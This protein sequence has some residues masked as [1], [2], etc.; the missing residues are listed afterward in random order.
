MTEETAHTQAPH[1]EAG[2]PAPGHWSKLAAQAEVP[3]MLSFSEYGEGIGN[4]S[5]V[6]RN[7]IA[8]AGLDAAV[9]TCPGWTARDLL[10]HVGMAQRWA[11][12]VLMGGSQRPVEEALLAGLADYLDPLDWLDEGAVGVLNALVKAPAGGDY[13]F[14]LKNAPADKREAW[15]RR[16]CHEATIHGVDAMAAR[17]GAAPAAGQ[18]WFKPSLAIDGIDELLRG[19]VPRR[20]SPLRTDTAQSLAVVPTDVSAPGG[21]WTVSFGPDAASTE[22]GVSADADATLSGSAI[23]L[24]LGLWNRVGQGGGEYEV[25]GDRAVAQTFSDRMKVEWIA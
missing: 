24:Y 19:F 15:A 1:P 5:S 3:S 4:A 22:L 18:V 10:V 21:G 23:G 20:S 2:E 25:T 16:Q 11:S 6:T 7:N 9:P 8:V 12:A 17:L 14:F 13:F